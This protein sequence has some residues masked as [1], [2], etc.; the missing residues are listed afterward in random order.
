MYNI[1]YPYP[2][3][4]LVAS[5]Q[6]GTLFF[7]LQTEK[8]AQELIP[9]LQSM[10]ANSEDLEPVLIFEEDTELGIHNYHLSC[11]AQVHSLSPFSIST[12]KNSLVK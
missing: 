10:Q 8:M 9:L 3:I 1:F 11:Y 12:L 6:K 5:I 7:H 4:I 2:A